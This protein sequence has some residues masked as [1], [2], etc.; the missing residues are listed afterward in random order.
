MFAAEMTDADD[1]DRDSLIS[2][3]AHETSSTGSPFELQNEQNNLSAPSIKSTMQYRFFNPPSPSD[4]F[5]SDVP[6]PMDE[7]SEMPNPP[8]ESYL[9][10]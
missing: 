4:Y 3:D 8:I 9:N 1:L 5:V 2:M 6:S 7:E 10:I